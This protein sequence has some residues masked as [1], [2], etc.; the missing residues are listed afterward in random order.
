MEFY[1]FVI[2]TKGT[3]NGSTQYIYEMAKELIDLG[4]KAEMLHQEK[5]FT[6]VGDWLGAEYDLI[7]HACIENENIKNLSTFK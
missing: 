6:G 2:D 5:E 7:P 1:F 4:Y 3:P